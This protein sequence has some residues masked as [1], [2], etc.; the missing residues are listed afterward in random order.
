MLHGEVAQHHQTRDV[1]HPTVLA[2]V[3]QNAAEAR[4]LYRVSPEF[5]EPVGNGCARVEFVPVAIVLAQIPVQLP[6]ELPPADD[7][8]DEALH[9]R[10]RR[11]SAPVGVLC[12]GHDLERVEQPEVHRCGQ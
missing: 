5:S 2:H 7:L 1:V 10:Q 8:P 11:S 9:R 4:R 12:P 6:H 3:G